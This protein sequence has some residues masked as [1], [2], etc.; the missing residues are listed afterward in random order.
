MD[1]NATDTGAENK[2]SKQ[3]QI[4]Q[5]VDRY[6]ENVRAYGMEQYVAD[7]EG[8]KFQAVETFQ[9]NFDLEAEDLAEMLGA[10]IGNN[11]LVTGANYNPRLMAIKLSQEYSD[12]MREALKVLL[13][14]G[15]ELQSRMERFK[16]MTDEVMDQRN[17]KHNDNRI[18]FFDIRFISL[19]L[20]MQYPDKYYYIKITEYRDFIN[21]IEGGGVKL[22]GS[23]YEK[24]ATILPYVEMLSAYLREQ[25]E[26]D[27]IRQ[28]MTEGL[29]FQDEQ[30]HW[31]AQDVVY[32]IN[33]DY[34][35]GDEGGSELLELLNDFV[36]HVDN[37]DSERNKFKG[38]YQGVKYRAWFGSSGETYL[39]TPWMVFGKDNHEIGSEWEDCRIILFYD[40][41]D[42]KLVLAYRWIVDGEPAPNPDDRY[43]SKN[44]FATGDWEDWYGQ[45]RATAEDPRKI[46][47][48]FVDEFNKLID[49]YHR[50]EAKQTNDRGVNMQK[51]PSLNTILYGPPGTGKTYQALNHY[52]TNLLEHQADQQR[53]VE[54]V[55]AD[56]L[57]ELRWW[58]V[59]ALALHQSGDSMKVG[60]LADTQIIR[61]YARYVKKRTGKVNATLWV[62]LQ[63]RSDEGSSNSKYRLH[64]VDYFTKQSG[65]RWTLTDIG[66]SFVE[67]AL[68]DIELNVEAETAT[69][70]KKFHST[71]TFHQSYSYEEFVE[72]IR[73]VI[74]EDDA[75]GSIRYE[76]KDGIFKEMCNLAINDPDNNYLLII[77]E[78]NCG[79]IAKIFGELITLLESDKR[80]GGEN[81]LKVRLPYSRE[82]FS[83]PANLYLLGTMNTADRSIALLDIA[84]R[85]R[86]TFV[87]AMP[88]Y[89]KLQ[90]IK[91]VDLAKL[92][93][94][95]NSK[96][97]AM[98]DRDHQI[99]HSYFMGVN[100]LEELH[101]AWYQK[102][103]PLLQEYFYNDWERLRI[104]LKE[105]GGDTGFVNI[106][107]QSELTQLFGSESG[108]DDAL[109]GTVH[110]YQPADLP[111]AL[112]DLYESPQ[113]N[114]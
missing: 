7:H 79:N 11:N 5:L 1:N 63:E 32:T 15:Q 44:D 40:W 20:S 60:E 42:S 95:I 47:Q 100:S 29:E 37:K 35:H 108:Y 112:I 107:P 92:L 10:A 87:E 66:R 18:T 67:E 27:E 91:G 22:S 50:M 104:V 76:I 57:T 62:A 53:S 64:D 101:D 93:H 6:I 43:I 34:L 2:Q 94:T 74:D 110:Y 33:K 13:D 68:G 84:L 80:L 90:T 106:K 12:E 71:I 105:Q 30:F 114:A 16:R 17:Q 102:V 86:F 28:A 25:P 113:E 98:I 51:L 23:I 59:V 72:G 49:E 111:S 54:E 78:I 56:N 85:R 26:A 109:V 81:E 4:K 3:L 39:K 48:S 77:D 38:E 99:G 83:I 96:V 89:D 41:T 52:A 82:T 88:D 14:E 24:Y 61:S 73:P 46:P 75:D 19:L 9:Q 65:S 97:E 21:Y 103:V 45:V 58:E 8:Y 31:M 36:E 55:L 70:W 69:N